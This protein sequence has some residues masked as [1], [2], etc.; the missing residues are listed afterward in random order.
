MDFNFSQLC[1][2]P[3]LPICKS[4]RVLRGFRRRGLQNLESK[5]FSCVWGVP[6][7]QEFQFRRNLWYNTKQQNNL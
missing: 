2:K 5:S 6:R 1:S 4:E 7:F 3:R